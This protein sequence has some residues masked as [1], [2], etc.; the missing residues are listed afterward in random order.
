MEPRLSNLSID[1]IQSVVKEM[2]P[3]YGMGSDT[4]G[5]NE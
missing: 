1:C 5:E 2:G 3:F 4:E